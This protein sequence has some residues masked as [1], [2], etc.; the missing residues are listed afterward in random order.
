MATKLQLSEGA[1]EESRMIRI[2]QA[3]RLHSAE[4]RIVPGSGRLTTSVRW[5]C[6]GM[7]RLS[8]RSPTEQ[9]M[10]NLMTVVKDSSYL[11]VIGSNT[12]RS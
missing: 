8:G 1:A 2:L 3:R 9:P 10:M 6:L 12:S 5:L 11:P 4:P 7:G